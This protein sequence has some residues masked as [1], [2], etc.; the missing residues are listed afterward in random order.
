MLNNGIV[1]TVIQM[2]ADHI[3]LDTMMGF[4]MRCFFSSLFDCD[5]KMCVILVRKYI[6]EL[7]SLI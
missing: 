3:V 1:Y 6:C 7:F 5:D 2:Y 4:M